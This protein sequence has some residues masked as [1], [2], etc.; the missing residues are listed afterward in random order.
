MKCGCF[1]LYW[2][3]LCW[4]ASYPPPTQRQQTGLGMPTV[5]KQPEGKQLFLSPLL[6]M[7]C[8]CKKMCGCVHSPSLRSQLRAHSDFQWCVLHDVCCLV[9]AVCRKLL[10]G[11]FICQRPTLSLLQKGRPPEVWLFPK[12]LP[13]ST[14]RA[15]R[16]FTGGPPSRYSR[17]QLWQK[18]M[19]Q[20]WSRFITS[21]DFSFIVCFYLI[22]PFSLFFLIAWLLVLEQFSLA[23]ISFYFGFILVWSWLALIYF[24]FIV[25]GTVLY[26]QNWT[27]SISTAVNLRLFWYCT[28]HPSHL[29]T[30]ILHLIIYC[31]HPMKEIQWT[32]VRTCISNVSRTL[33]SIFWYDL[34]STGQKWVNRASVTAEGCNS[35]VPRKVKSTSPPVAPA[36]ITWKRCVAIRSSD[37]CTASSACQ[38][39][40]TSCWLVRPRSLIVWRRDINS[41]A[42]RTRTCLCVLSRR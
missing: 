8:F 38:A 42:R 14:L 3:A 26:N 1:Q 30:Y 40:A 32:E 11:G 34:C 33:K 4:L 36:C 16:G 21:L 10:R 18:H 28:L 6:L 19:S 24:L 2:K 31:I 13:Q 9:G 12:R 7:K 37:P 27:L 17:L 41:V 25:Y 23:F 29:D 35:P 22:L 20:V 5:V 39:P 15:D